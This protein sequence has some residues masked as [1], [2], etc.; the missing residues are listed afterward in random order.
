MKQN[1]FV[2]NMQS[3]YRCCWSVKRKSGTASSM[4]TESQWNKQEACFARATRL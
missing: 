3:Y 2:Y 1:S 4:N